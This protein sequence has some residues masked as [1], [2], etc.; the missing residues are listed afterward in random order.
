MTQTT[1]DAQWQQ[2]CREFESAR[3]ALDQALTPVNQKFFLI[4]Q[5][6]S[7]INPTD[8]ELS[9]LEAAHRKFEDIIRRMRQ[10][11]KVHTGAA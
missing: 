7:H 5:G 6:T 8:D 9:R 2:F 3:E 4:A 10:F 1:L 11:V